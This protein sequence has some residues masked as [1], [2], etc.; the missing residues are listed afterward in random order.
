MLH[1]NHH[2][3][4]QF[5]RGKVVLE[6]ASYCGFT[7][8][9]SSTSSVRGKKKSVVISLQDIITNRELMKAFKHEEELVQTIN[10]HLV[11]VRKNA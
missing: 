9:R 8:L 5:P 4:H 2:S 1:W 6:K 3:T 7:V 10:K 11:E